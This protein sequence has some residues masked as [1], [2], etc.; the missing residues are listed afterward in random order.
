MGWIKVGWIRR[1]RLLE[2]GAF[3]LL[4]GAASPDPKVA[5][6]V[7]QLAQARN[8]AEARQLEIGLE[9]LRMQSVQPAVRLLQR[10]SQRELA[11]GNP[12][13]ALSDMQDAMG[14]QPD[15][16]L[17]WREQAAARAANGDFDGAVSD[18]GGALSRDPDDGLAWQALALFEEDRQA[19]MAAYKAWQHV[20]SLDPQVQDGAKRL[21]RLRRHALGQP[22]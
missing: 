2:S 21:D 22:A 9:G 19:W 18:L 6:M 12:R 8:H 15:N 5:V 10:R 16:A 13:A 1:R 3:L 20:L 17:L 14:L 11:S 7:K 4:L